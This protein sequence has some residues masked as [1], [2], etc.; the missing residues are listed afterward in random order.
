MA[1]YFLLGLVTKKEAGV[2]VDIARNI[3]GVNRVFKAFEYI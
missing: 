1:R 2:A 3:N